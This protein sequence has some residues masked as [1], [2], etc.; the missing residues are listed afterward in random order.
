MNPSD[1]ILQLH[2]YNI[3][4]L[5]SI[6]EEFNL[7]INNE[8]NIKNQILDCLLQ[9]VN[10][11]KNRYSFCNNM[12]CK[13]C[14]YKSFLSNS[15]SLYWREDNVDKNGNKITPRFLC[16]G[17][18]YKAKFLCNKCHHEFNIIL[19]ENTRKG[20]WCGFCVNKKLCNNDCNLCFNNSFASSDKAKYWVA[21]KNIDKLGHEISPRD[22][23]KHSHN[24]YW[25]KC[26]KCCH[27]FDMTLDNT[28][29]AWCCFCAHQK[30]CKSTHCDFCFNNSFASSDKA[31]YWLIGKNVDKL[32]HQ[33]SPKDVFKSS[34]M[35]GWFKCDK[36]NHEFTVILGEN[37]RN[38]RW[39]NLCAN[40]QLCKNNDCN[41]CFNKSFASSDKAKYWVTEKNIDKLGHEIS[42]RDVFK[43]S[44]NKYWFKCDKCCHEFDKNLVSVINSKTWCCFCGNRQ[45]CDKNDCNSCFNKSFASSDRAKYW[46]IGKNKTSPRDLFKLSGKKYWFKCEKNHEFNIG[47]I[48]LKNNQWCRHCINKTETIIFEYLSINYNC[49]IQSIFDWCKNQL[50]SRLLP[51]DILLPD[52]KLI[53]EIDGRQHF[54]IVNHWKTNVKLQQNND[55]FKMKCALQNGYTVIRLVQEE[56]FDNKIDWKYRL[57]Q[58][59]KLYDKPQVIFISNIPNIYD[60]HVFDI[61]DE[62]EYNLI[63]DKNDE[64]DE[65]DEDMVDDGVNLM[66]YELNTSEDYI[67]EDDMIDEYVKIIEDELILN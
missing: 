37:T 54:K 53:I 64:N 2:S 36:C 9:D 43:H 10:C 14:Y 16:K 55:K 49:V 56:V 25:F 21:E 59:I 42:P 6:C 33:I 22:V 24:K 57:H 67:L 45:L 50:T 38:N 17:S 4:K 51:F 29:K 52:Y 19:G 5:L 28:K 62:L 15:K 12:L 3:P 44:H 1:I 61:T 20:N 63:E 47:L 30:L 40:Q 35:K 13:T 34:D 41:S 39:C 26:D 11:G 60:N 7:P 32:G 65:N 31:K 18:D 46:L 27:E 66:E 23:F 8:N 48:R 58:A